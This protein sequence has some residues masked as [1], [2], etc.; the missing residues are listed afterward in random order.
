[1]P[2]QRLFQ[3]PGY[4]HFKQLR[5]HQQLKNVLA[6]LFQQPARGPND[7]NPGGASRPGLVELDSVRD[8]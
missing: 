8:E 5:R 1:M 4:K 2:R 7:K 6:M 3:H